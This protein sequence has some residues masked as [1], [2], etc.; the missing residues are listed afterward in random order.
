MGMTGWLDDRKRRTPPP[1]T[2]TPP[3]Q[4]Q[5]YP[6]PYNFYVR[7]GPVRLHS[8]DNCLLLHCLGEAGLSF[9]YDV[10]V[11]LSG[12]DGVVGQGQLGGLD[13]FCG[14]GPVAYWAAAGGGEEGMGKGKGPVTPVEAFYNPR[15]VCGC[16]SG[17]G[18]SFA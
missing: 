5:P 10:N 15:C 12:G 7:G 13:P 8:V 1:I 18:A 11:G 3:P 17:V 16:G 6:R 14:G 9:V 4:V 2:P